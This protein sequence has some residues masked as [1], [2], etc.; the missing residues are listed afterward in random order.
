[1]AFPFCALVCQ[2]F[3]HIEAS[4]LKCVNLP[5]VVS[6]CQQKVPEPFF[7]KNLLSRIFTFSLRQ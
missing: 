2:E 5:E 3:P 1:M 4:S 6:T 7:S